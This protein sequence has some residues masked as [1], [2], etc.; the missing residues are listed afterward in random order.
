MLQW[1]HLT[2]SLLLSLCV[3]NWLLFSS[4]TINA[5][6]LDFT[7]DLLCSAIHN[8]VNQIFFPLTQ[9]INSETYE[10]KS[11]SRVNMHGKKFVPCSFVLDSED[12][13]CSGFRLT[14]SDCIGLSF[15]FSFSKTS[16]QTSLKVQFWFNTMP[17]TICWPA[18]CSSATQSK[19]Y[20]D[21]LKF[22]LNLIMC[23]RLFNR[24]PL[25]KS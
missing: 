9:Q 1:S 23:E 22:G 12:S 25:L 11:G 19:N 16:A 7:T 5:Q 6:K 13:G 4:S 20:I 10:L 2:I 8:T 14:R 15:G 3:D 18:L 21:S 24:Q 17:R